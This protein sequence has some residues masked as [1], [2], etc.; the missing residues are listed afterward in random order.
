MLQ[1]VPTTPWLFPEK[2]EEVVR[3]LLEWGCIKCDE[4][5][6]LP[7]KSGGRTDV[8]VNLRDARDYPEAIHFVS[9]LFEIPLRHLR[10]NRFVEVPDA[11]SCFAGP[12]SLATGIP[13]LTIREQEKMGRVADARIIGHPVRGESVYIL[14][15]VIT[16]G[17]SKIVPIE[18]CLRLGL[19]VK[20]LVVLVN[21]EQ[22]WK[23]KFA[24]QE[25]SVPVWAG[26][27]LHDVRRQLIESGAM[28]RCDPKA[29]EKNPIILA[30]D[31]KSWEEI[32]PVIDPLRP[33]G[34]V[35]K[36]N[37][38]AFAE[39]FDRL[40]PDLSVY[41]R[42]MLDLKA[43]DIPNTVGNIMSRVRAHAPWA[44]TVHASGGEEM[45]RAAVK[46]LEGTQTM[47]LAVTVL[48]SLG[49]DCEEIYTRSPLE[50]VKVLAA[51]ADR[52]GAHGFVCAPEEARELRN[53]YPDALIVTPGVR[54]SGI[55]SGD[56]KRV[57]TP[58][59][60]IENGANMV[61][62]GRQFLNDSDPVAEVR[63]VLEQELGVFI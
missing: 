41:G 61:V 42:V 50:Q 44:V 38:L 58:K 33:M 19:S 47:I 62:G 3:R 30:L 11:V 10:V 53:L 20:A 4:A 27:T 17:A 34:C 59:E 55:D 12:L 54:S 2:Q 8:Y 60:A 46:A 40:L 26:M 13:Y 1:V 5:R 9:G 35:L 23:R 21:R 39:G 7:L 45:I 48:T 25:I 22:G 51:I 49:P 29:E 16:D 56:Q 37:D 6:S 36:V 43:H 32:L 14:D 63:R 31:G 18:E 24:E 28:R 57:M 15:D 52:A